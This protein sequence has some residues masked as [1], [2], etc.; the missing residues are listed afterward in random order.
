MEFKV[1]DRVKFKSGAVLPKGTEA[2]PTISELLAGGYVML[3]W[4]D[5]NGKQ[6][7]SGCH[8]RELDLVEPRR[9]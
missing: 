2:A 6:S 8:L 3:L 5:Q 4:V 7:N 9:R 1:G